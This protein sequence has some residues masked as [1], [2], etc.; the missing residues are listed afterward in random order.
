MSETPMSITPEFSRPV[1]VASIGARGLTLE[2]EAT[3]EERAALVRRFDLLALDRLSARL[4]VTQGSGGAGVTLA[5]DL[6]ADLVQRC[7]LTLGPVPEHIEDHFIQRF[8]EDAPTD[9]ELFAM[10]EEKGLDFLLDEEDPPEPIENGRIDLGEAVVQQ[11]A[12]MLDPYP[13]AEDAALQALRPGITVND[14]TPLEK[15]NPFAKLAQLR[16]KS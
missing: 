13:R 6:L 5:G 16:E 2:I 11:F 8:T 7:V 15:N 3:E 12:V 4:R 14:E 9:E 10:I 1:E